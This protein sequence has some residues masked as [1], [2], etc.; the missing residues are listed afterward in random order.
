MVWLA[1][2][3]YFHPHRVA[4]PDKLTNTENAI[5]TRTSR[6]R[7]CSTAFPSCGAAIWAR[8]RR[9]QKGK[10]FSFELDPN[11]LTPTGSCVRLYIQYIDH[12]IIHLLDSSLTTEALLSAPGGDRV[13]A[14]L[15][16]RAPKRAF[17]R[18]RRTP[19]CNGFF[20]DRR[21]QLPGAAKLRRRSGISWNCAAPL[22]PITNQSKRIKQNAS[23]NAFKKASS[24]K[25]SSTYASLAYQIFEGP[26]RPALRGE[27]AAQLR[28]R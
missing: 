11:R 6:R 13:A 2:A 5:R 18:Q 19:R 28:G 10:T 1:R 17:P 14:R 25:A 20:P 12:I 27:V 3:N 4:R 26:R 15:R 22:H 21:R 9:A 8:M 23:K 7:S 16:H 24:E